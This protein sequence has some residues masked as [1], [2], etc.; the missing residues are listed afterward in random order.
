LRRGAHFRGL[1][2][3]A[4]RKLVSGRRG[5][6]GL[7]DLAVSLEPIQI[8]QDGR[9]RLLQRRGNIRAGKLEYPQSLLRSQERQDF[10]R[11]LTL[12]YVWSE[13]RNG[14]K[15]DFGSILVKNE[16]KLN[17][18]WRKNGLYSK[19]GV[20]LE[21]NIRFLLQIKWGAEDNGRHGYMAFQPA[22]TDISSA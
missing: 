18:K 20:K 17:R 5:V 10:V 22:G 6:T 9:R 2:A 13:N 4:D 15:M 14:S 1:G 11:E 7:L 21:R 16:P 8:A 12:R 19:C 3:I